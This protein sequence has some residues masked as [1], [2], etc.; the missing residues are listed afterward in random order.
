[1]TNSSCPVPPKWIRK[2]LELFLDA[3]VLE[4]CLGDLEEKFQRNLRN[5]TPHWK[6]AILYSLEGL[7]FIKMASRLNAL[8][9][10]T[11]INTLGHTFLFLSRLVKRDKSYYLASLLGLT[12]SLASFLFIAMFIKDE[13]AYDQ[14]HDNKDQ[15]YRL[16]THIRIGEVENDMATSQFPAAEALRSELSEVE[17]TVRIFPQDVNVELGD[18]KFKDHAIF[19]DQNFFE[20]FS[21][22]LLH[23]DL[24][25]ALS[26]PESIIL[27]QA[28]AKKY[29]GAETAIGKNITFN[30]HSL[31]VTG[32]VQDIPEQSHIKCDV[33]IPLAMQLTIW[34]RETGLEGRENKWYWTGTYTY[35]LLK[36]KFDVE[37]VQAK[38][39]VVVNR[40]FPE[41][42]KEKGRF[43]L[44]P[45]T[46]IH[47]KSN[48]SAEL[49]PGGSML[50]VRMFS[51]VAIMI[52]VVSSINLINL[53]WFKLTGRMREL[54]IRKFLGQ[55]S[56]TVIAQLS[57]ESILGGVLAFLM[58]MVV[59]T[60]QLQNF[61]LF[62]EKNLKLWSIS[63]L[64]LIG[65]TLLMVISICLLAVIRPAIHFATQASAPLLLRKYRSPRTARVQNVLV[66]MQVCFSFVLLVFSLM[67]N[68][69]ID[70]LMEKDLGFDKTNIVVVE[71]NE[72]IYPNMEAFKNELK[73]SKAIVNVACGPSPGNELN[74]W[75]FVP[76]GG[77]REK[78]FLFSLLWCDYNY[79]NTLKIRL[80]M[81]ENFD[82]NKTYDSLLPFVIN[83]RTAVELGWIGDP[84]EKT[85]EIFAP[86]TTKIMA[87]GKVI[88]VVDDFHFGSLHDVVKPII[89]AATNRPGTAIIR[90]SNNA[91][92][93]A[94][95][96][97]GTI[98]KHFSN[99]PFTY[100]FL[101]KKLEGL[102]SNEEKLSAIILFFTFI[103]LFLTCYG[104][105]AMSSLLFRSRLKEVS[106]RKVFGAGNFNILRQF[107]SRYAISNLIAI[108]MG[109]PAAL[110]MGEL[111][112]ETFQYRIELRPS[113]FIDAGVCIVLAGPL[114][115][116]YYL[117]R[118][119]ISNPIQFLRRE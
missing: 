80:L 26:K 9:F 44:Q 93:D 36:D 105:F 117:I 7:G 56:A 16:T 63:N 6:A 81:G 96:H 51:I 23:G 62:V 72:D 24:A 78:P 109:I 91:N 92:K 71:L 53:S 37:G 34:K 5:N 90:I 95:V 69:Q 45:L 74:E 97:I 88:G 48:L 52:L 102:Y 112:L 35:L 17:Q 118:V 54:G 111:W 107:Y 14:F 25:T 86:G 11:T 46:D 15:I 49:E 70:F 40:Y 85:I 12:L 73:K 20:V 59:C 100:G 101:E 83:K 114:S 64:S 106:I 65:A 10:Q 61:N 30:G 13:L 33:I 22:R 38:L 8:S 66:G 2:V 75:R 1:M 31:T 104:M 3:R 29:F 39:P 47:L 42:Y 19:V 32:I 94:L 84:L 103:S 21:F 119:T 28:T 79:V 76:E 60:V 27:T 89:L 82:P 57:I 4:A 116:G 67:V 99:K 50:Y 115:M 87:K 113:F 43:E 110:Y 98:W 68:K 108:A 77:S 58:A 18:I 55:S 41:R